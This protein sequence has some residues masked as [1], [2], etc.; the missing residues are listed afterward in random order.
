MAGAGSSS[1]SSK[2]S[3]KDSGPV[4]SSSSLSGKSVNSSSSNNNGRF[5]LRFGRILSAVCGNG[6]LEGTGATGPQGAQVEI[7]SMG[8]LQSQYD[9]CTGDT[10]LRRHAQ[11]N[12]AG[13]IR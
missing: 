12:R 8:G 9:L 10:S 7:G 1:G 4:P 6:F 2:R 3:S 5:R 11:S 13:N